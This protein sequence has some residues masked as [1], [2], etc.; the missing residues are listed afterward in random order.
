MDVRDVWVELEGSLTC[1]Y[2]ESDQ[3]ALSGGY[4]GN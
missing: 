1:E 2:M 4:Y 3:G